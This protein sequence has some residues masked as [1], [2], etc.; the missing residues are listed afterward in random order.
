MRI[1]LDDN[2]F[3][4]LT[5]GDIVKKDEIE[6]ALSD[7]GYYKMIYIIENNLNNSKISK[8]NEINYHAI[9]ILKKLNKL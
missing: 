1:L 8:N 4:K 7:I 2:D 5:K 6:I 9:E 3:D